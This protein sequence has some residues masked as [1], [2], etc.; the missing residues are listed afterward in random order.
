MKVGGAS[1]AVLMGPDVGAAGGGGAPAPAPV[2]PTATRTPEEAS[3]ALRE[4]IHMRKRDAERAAGFADDVD[5]PERDPTKKKRPDGEGG[6]DAAAREARRAEKFGRN[7]PGTP[8]ER[9]QSGR[10]LPKDGEKAAK[11]EANAAVSQ[12]SQAKPVEGE[13][14]AEGEP[15]AAKDEKKDEDGYKVTKAQAHQIA[16]Q[17]TTARKEAAEA[18]KQNADWDKMAERVV[19]RFDSFQSRIQYLEGLVSELGG[20]VD[21]HLMENLTLKEQIQAQKLGEER[22]QQEAQARQQAAQESARK[23]AFARDR[24][25]LQTS[26]VGI[27]KQHPELSPPFTEENAEAGRFWQEIQAEIEAGRGSM[28]ELAP[29]LA[30]AQYV[31]MAVQGR[32]ATAR[33]QVPPRT[34]ANMSAARGEPRVTDRQSI[35]EKHKQRLRA[36]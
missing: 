21:P 22:A 16:Q 27:M 10:F 17:L 24:Q 31:A 34:L 32:R 13:K 14:P 30:A 9:D 36:I 15:D 3:Q 33:T 5:L 11:P 4:K 29:R 19:A 6:S 18:K 35:V 2:A 12:G 26:L 7:A 20:N 28:Q 1:W 23:Q 8:E 25:Q